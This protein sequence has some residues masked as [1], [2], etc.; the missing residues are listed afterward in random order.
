M[1]GGARCRTRG[2]FVVVSQVSGRADRKSTRKAVAGAL[3]GLDPL[4]NLANG[5]FL[6]S[7]SV[8]FCMTR[9]S[10]SA[11]LPGLARCL[12]LVALALGLRCARARRPLITPVGYHQWRR[13]DKQ[14]HRVLRL[15]CKL[16]VAMA[17]EPPVVPAF[18][19]KIEPLL[20]LHKL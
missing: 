6:I 17:V 10:L 15:A 20:S 12:V 5:S 14:R 8:D 9:I 1:A 16:S 7:R 18:T 2:R 3:W 11:L 19:D 13:G 4:T